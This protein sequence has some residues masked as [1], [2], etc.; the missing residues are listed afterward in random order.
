[1]VNYNYKGYPTLQ[2]EKSILAIALT[3]VV[4]NN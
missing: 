3:I 1:M 2:T 4:V